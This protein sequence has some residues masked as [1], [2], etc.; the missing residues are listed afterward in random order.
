MQRWLQPQFV[1]SACEKRGLEP[2]CGLVAFV[3]LLVQHV[4]SALEVCVEIHT[5]IFNA[6]ISAC[7]ATKW[8]A[9]VCV[10]AM[11]VQPQLE[12]STI[13]GERRLCRC[14]D[15][16]GLTCGIASAKLATI[17]ASISSVVV[18]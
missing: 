2:E 10:T 8:S 1:I 9:E 14:N 6:A 5:I 15:T 18:R 17:R 4:V 3:A 13:K 7:K 11:Y 12:G 16:V